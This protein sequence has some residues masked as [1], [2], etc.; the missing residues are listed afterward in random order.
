MHLCIAASL[1]ALA[2]L[3]CATVCDETAP[4][5]NAVDNATNHLFAPLMVCLLHD[6]CW[7]LEPGRQPAPESTARIL[8]PASGDL[9][10]TKGKVGPYVSVGVEQHRRHGPCC[11]RID[12]HGP[13]PTPAPS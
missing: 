13:P 5:A 11:G 6:T 4:R 12:A 2:A 9:N 10:C 3:S 8:S 7:L 1:A